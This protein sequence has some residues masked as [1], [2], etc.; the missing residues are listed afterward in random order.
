MKTL[1]EKLLPK[2]KYQLEKE[3]DTYPNIVKDLKIQLKENYFIVELTIA[4]AFRL[5][6]A[7]TKETLTYLN[8]SN[9]F[10]L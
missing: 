6:D 4:D 2:H 7:T 3:A 10:E 9:L 5:L 1:F 8:L